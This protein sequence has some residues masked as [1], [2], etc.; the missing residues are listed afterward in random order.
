MTTHLSAS[1][2]ASNGQAGASAPRTAG[3]AV[4]AALAA[5]TREFHNLVAD[6]EELVHATSALTGEELARAKVKLQARVS[7]ART[8]LGSVASD[9]SERARSSAQSAD[10]Y[11]RAQPWRAVGITA[12]AGLLIGFLLGRRR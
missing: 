3:P 12:A 1:E 11:V 10:K 7:A 9:M 2:T 8:Y 5:V 4:D 6:V